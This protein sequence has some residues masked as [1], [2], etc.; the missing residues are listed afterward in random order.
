MM[1]KRT[2]YRVATGLRPTDITQVAFANTDFDAEADS[3][4]Q[5]NNLQRI[6]D[7]R[8]QGQSDGLPHLDPLQELGF[9]DPLLLRQWHLYNKLTPGNDINVTPVWKSGITGKGVTVCIIDDGI[10]HTHRDLQR[11]FVHL[12]LCP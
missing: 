6:V 3:A 4:R 8:K 12:F 5:N 7:L 1:R 9:N 10:D 2:S 11:A